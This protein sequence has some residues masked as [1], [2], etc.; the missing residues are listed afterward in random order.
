MN[1]KLLFP[2]LTAIFFFSGCITLTKELPPYATYTLHLSNPVQESTIPKDITL[3]IKEPHALQSIN[4]QFIFY[5]T[6]HFK[7]EQYALSK[8][9]DKPSKMI[10]NQIIKYLSNTKNYQYIN[11]SNIHVKNNY[12][13]LSEIENFQQ[14][15]RE[16][17]SFVEF[18]I[19]L[20]L[21]S[22]TDTVYKK[23]HYTQPCLTNNAQGAVVAYN[24]VLQL[25]VQDLDNWI[26]QS[27]EKGGK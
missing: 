9:S 19:H 7:S 4:S 10:Q 17:N 22:R 23:F 8:W 3:E 24:Q 20:Y 13:L 15:F 12:Q 6:N 27:I 21:V 26:V 25:F 2:L 11:S 18:S 1:A 5:A 14:Y 16:N